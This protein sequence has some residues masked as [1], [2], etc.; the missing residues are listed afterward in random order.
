[1]L[2]A[3]LTTTVSPAARAA[4][5]DTQL[6]STATA[7]VPL[8][9]SLSTSA[10]VSQRFRESALGDDIL[11][12]RA[13]LDRKL[14]PTVAIGAGLTYLESARGHEWRPHQQLVINIAPF[15]LRSQLEERF[16][17]GV[18]RTQFRLRERAQLAL[19]LDSANRFVGS[20]E[21]LYIVR[22]AGPADRARVDSLRGYLA[23]QH[24]FSTALSASAG[25]MLIFTER[26]KKPD[27]I[28]HAPQ[29]A[30]IW[31]L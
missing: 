5:S 8:G 19:P 24:Q 23:L 28:T 7:I 6:W 17:Q 10:L 12:L 2:A 16:V 15:S 4:G 25:Y 27:Q 31:R 29:I 18:S 13:T 30:L 1:M 3:T 14:I 21:L 22:A 26:P 20:G 11:L 9:P